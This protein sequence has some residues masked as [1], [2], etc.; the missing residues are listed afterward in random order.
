MNIY[1]NYECEH[2]PN[3]RLVIVDGT[4]FIQYNEFQCFECPQCHSKHYQCKEC[5]SMLFTT[6]K[7]I[8]NHVSYHKR[9]RSDEIDKDEDGFQTENDFVNENRYST[10]DSVGVE[11][12]LVDSNYTHHCTIAED[13]CD[14]KQSSSPNTIQYTSDASNH[15]FK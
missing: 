12:S 5:T 13:S 11:G 9:K 3:Q 4:T 6:K 10:Q 15:F 14:M 1:T 8:N 2:C 7:Q